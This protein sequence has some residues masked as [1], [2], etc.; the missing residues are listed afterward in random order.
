MRV[1]DVWGLPPG[2]ARRWGAAWFAIVA[3][4]LALRLAAAGGDFWLD[5]VVSLNLARHFSALEI[6]AAPGARHDNNH[7]LNTL[8]LHAVEGAA[9][10]RIYRALSIASGVATVVLMGWIG[11]RRSRRAALLAEWRRTMNYA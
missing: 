4:A 5:E 6:V 3:T 8:Y 2:A 9:S 11:G 1:G 10:E 7:V